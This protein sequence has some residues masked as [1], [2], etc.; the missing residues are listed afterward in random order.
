MGW[1]QRCMHGR[2]RH[3]SGLA[4]FVLCVYPSLQTRAHRRLY[5]KVQTDRQTDRQ[6]VRVVHFCVCRSE[7]VVPHNDRIAPPGKLRSLLPTS[8]HTAR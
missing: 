8:I 5:V 3:T 7:L 6:T 4:A 1:M 2:S